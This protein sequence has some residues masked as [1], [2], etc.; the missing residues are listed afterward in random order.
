MNQP[1]CP[2]VAMA[3]ANAPNPLIGVSR[4]SQWLFTIIP[5]MAAKKKKG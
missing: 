5:Q 1:S 4:S 2:A 3:Y